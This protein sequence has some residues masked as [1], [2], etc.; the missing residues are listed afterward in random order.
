MN[1]IQLLFSAVI[2]FIVYKFIRTQIKWI[3]ERKE[4]D[5]LFS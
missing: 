1:L 5:R 2:L 4:L 3:N